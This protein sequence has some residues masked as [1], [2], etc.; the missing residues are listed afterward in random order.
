MSDER[1]YAPGS[2]LSRVLCILVDDWE[3]KIEERER[4]PFAASFE[5]DQPFPEHALRTPSE[6]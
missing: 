1:F 6:A 5:W 2:H 3:P 4:V